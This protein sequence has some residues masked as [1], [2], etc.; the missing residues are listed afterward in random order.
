[1]FLYLIELV[2][3]SSK[4]TANDIV[5]G[6]G[7]FPIVNGEFAIN[8]GKF[9]VPI[10]YGGVDFDTNFSTTPFLRKLARAA[11]ARA[12]IISR[13][14]YSM[15]PHILSTLANSLLMGKIFAS[16]TAVVM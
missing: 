9:K 3:L 15:P 12:A 5:V 16:A 4:D 10:L 1:M 2:Y 14:S 13:L 7:A 6:W 8:A 11:H